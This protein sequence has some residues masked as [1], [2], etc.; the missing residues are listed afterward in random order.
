M[1]EGSKREKK[2]GR[3]TERERGREIER[4]REREREIGGYLICALEDPALVRN[5]LE[6]W[7]QF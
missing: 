7:C 2:K 4:E 1:R 3:E 6:I 5:Q